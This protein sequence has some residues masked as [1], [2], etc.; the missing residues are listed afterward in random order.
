M[1]ALSTLFACAFA[2]SAF[3]Q[4][5]YANLVIESQPINEPA[6]STI[7]A[8]LGSAAMSYRLYAEIPDNYEIQI[9]FGLGETPF[10]ISA[11]GGTFYQDVLGGPSTLSIDTDLIPTNPTLAYDSWLTIGAEQMDNNQIFVL[12]GDI[13]F[14]GWEAGSDLMIN[15]LFGAGIYMTTVF[16]DPQNTADVN[17]RVL[18]GQFTASEFVS[19]CFNIQLRRLNEDGTVFM[20]GE[21]QPEIVLFENTCF[22]AEPEMNNCP[23]DLDNSGNILI[24]DVLL[25]LQDYGCDSNCSADVNGDDA[26][27]TLDLLMMLSVF[28][29][30]CPS[31]E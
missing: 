14:A 1:K 15:D 4:N 31:I 17:G 18:L 13:A 21:G 6:A 27:T 5:P 23:A 20:D 11:N 9:I 16:E 12:P 30:P 26:V 28:G 19:G 24:N 29:E 10:S 22:S 2:L 8:T 7:E 3:A 25:L